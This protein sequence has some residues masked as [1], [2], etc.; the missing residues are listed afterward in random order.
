MSPE[1]TV[2]FKLDVN[3]W[4]KWDTILEKL[5]A[6]NNEDKEKF[7]S[8]IMDDKKL[9]ISRTSGLCG[10]SFRFIMFKDG[11][12]QM[13]QI[14]SDWHK[15]FLDSIEVSDQIFNRE[16]G[17]LFSGEWPKKYRPNNI[18]D[19]SIINPLVITPEFIGFNS[20][21]PD[22]SVLEEEKLSRIPF[23]NILSFF[24]NLH[25]KYDI[26]MYAIKSFPHEL[27]KKLDENKVEYKLDSPEDY[28]TGSQLNT[29]LIKMDIPKGNG[30]FE[31]YNQR[32]LF[33]SFYSKYYSLHLKLRFWP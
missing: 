21:L 20:I 11:V 6:V 26:E 19:P 12:S 9:N 29:E 1:K 17:L 5:A 27:Q 16:N 18:S 24:I 32:M 31:V 14:W 33:H 22:G 7:L 23:K 3:I 28:G 8:G 4:P 10:K 15:T 2:S 13:E 30:A 25:V